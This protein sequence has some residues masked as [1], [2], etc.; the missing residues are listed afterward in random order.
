MKQE[1]ILILIIGLF[2]A[3]YVLEAI[4]QPLGLDL[5]TPYHY[6]NPETLMTYPFTTT[7]IVVRA[8]AIF[9]SPLWLMS[10]IG[11][12]YSLKGSVSLV[13]AG[14]TQLYALQELATGNKIL[15]LEWALAISLAG[16]ALLI[17][18]V[19]YFLRAILHSAHT[20]LAGASEEIP[21]QARDDG[22]D[23]DEDED[24]QD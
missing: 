20:K 17:P 9:L 2:L 7:V 12:N 5:T 13:L 8:I 22:D 18:M 15:P 4:V 24:D 3:A 23:E 1:Y 21:G 6:L 16:L 11:K 19:I 10:F 14:L